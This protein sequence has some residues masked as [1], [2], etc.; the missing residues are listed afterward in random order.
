[1]WED[2]G[3]MKIVKMVRVGWKGGIN[4]KVLRRIDSRSKWL[5]IHITWIFMWIDRW[6]WGGVIVEKRWGEDA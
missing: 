4:E 2:V 3:R 1:M 5:I 6:W